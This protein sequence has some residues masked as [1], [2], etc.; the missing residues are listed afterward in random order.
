M[1]LKAPVE[2]PVGARPAWQQEELWQAIFQM[3]EVPLALSRADGRFCVANTAFCRTF[4]LREGEL[5]GQPCADLFP[6]AS[7]AMLARTFR[8]SLAAPPST[9]TLTASLAQPDGTRRCLEALVSAVMGP[10]RPEALLWVVHDVTARREYEAQLTYDALH[11]AL[12]GLPNRRLFQDRLDQATRRAQRTGHPM[13]VLVLD[14]DGFKRINDELGHSVGDQ[15]LAELAG[16][17][18]HTVRASDTV[19]RLGGDEFGMVIEGGNVEHGVQRLLKKL[20]DELNEPVLVHTQPLAISVSVGAARF[21]IDGTD[22]ASLL[23]AADQAMYADKRAHRGAS[24]PVNCP[25]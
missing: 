13:A 17:L 6:A 20:H 19:A 4:D 5:V 18:A 14:L 8:Y 3:A 21:P 22:P 9:A 15:A 24:G 7:P 1:Q 12:T 11:D 25:A 2:W 23:Q 10:D 16:R